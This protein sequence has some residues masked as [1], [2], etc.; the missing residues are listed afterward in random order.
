M[1]FQIVTINTFDR[2]SWFCKISFGPSPGS[3]IKFSILSKFVDCYKNVWF[4]E[5]RFKPNFVK[6]GKF[7]NVKSCYF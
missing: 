7:L 5:I 6:P 1:V 2:D 3:D 4:C